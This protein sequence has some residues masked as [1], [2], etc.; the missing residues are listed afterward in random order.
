MKPYLYAAPAVVLLLSACQ[1]KPPT[2]PSSLDIT[3]RSVAIVAAQQQV[4]GLE[5]VINSREG[6]PSD[7][8]HANSNRVA[9]SWDGDAVELLSYMARQRGMAFAWTGIRLP[10]PV[11]IHVSGITYQNLLRMIELQIA[12]R[13][14]L[15][16]Y[17]GQLTLAF[18][19]TEQ[20]GGHKP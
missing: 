10:L 8:I 1:Q 14:R 20:H 18:Y 11:T 7:A 12:W 2:P 19:I 4:L 17:P 15:V 5:D 3:S 13:A 6:M 16:E 9:V